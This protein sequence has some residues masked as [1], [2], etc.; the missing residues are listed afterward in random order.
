MKKALPIGVDNFKDIITKPYYYVDKT[1]LV[2]ELLDQGG[3]VNLFTRPRRFGKTLALSMLKTYFEAEYDAEGNRIDNS[4][5]FDGMKIMD[6]GEK[7]TGHLGRYPVISLSLKSAKQ[8]SFDMAYDILIDHIASEFLRHRYIL[9][10]DALVEE[11]KKKYRLLMSRTAPKSEYATSVQFLSKCLESFHKQ[12]TIILIDEYDVPL[13]NSWFRGFYGEMLD[14]I[15][16]LFESALK[17][18]TVWHLLL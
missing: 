6:T 1:L 5:Y 10:S 13:E 12:K 7:Y 2:K 16:S 4:H 17:T 18:N 11:V 8:P 14:F 3:S 15:R 9:Q